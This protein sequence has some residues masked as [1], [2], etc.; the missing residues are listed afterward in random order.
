MNVGGFSPNIYLF[1][2]NILNNR[3]IGEKG[4]K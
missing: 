1:S 4:G 2:P 3:N